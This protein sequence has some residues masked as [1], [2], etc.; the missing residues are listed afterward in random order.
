MKGVL[1][2]LITALLAFPAAAQTATKQWV[3]DPAK[4]EIAFTARNAGHEFSGIFKDWTA[5]IRFNPRRL[6]LSSVVVT[7]E[8]GS[9]ATGNNTY[10]GTLPA[11]GWFDTKTF[12]QAV[13]KASKFR[14]FAPE[15]PNRYEATGTLRIKGIVQP[16]VLPFTLSI[17][18]REA[19]ME[20]EVVV[21]RLAFE[22]GKG[23]DPTGEW[24]EKDVK[25]HVKVRA[26]RAD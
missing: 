14:N 19:V 22:V 4:S 17:K 18:G 23:A 24:V 21:D 13:F 15:E 10:D 20:G 16:L 6:A 11:E 8:T 25:V 7:I 3:V 26:T 2:Y 5:D 12:P 9:V 1:I